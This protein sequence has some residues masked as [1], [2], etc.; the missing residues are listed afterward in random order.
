MILYKTIFLAVGLL[1]F[2][3][4]LFAQ[5]FALGVRDG[6]SISTISPRES[7]YPFEVPDFQPSSGLHAGIEGRLALGRRFAILS[8]L[9][10]DRKGYNMKVRFID[11][12]PSPGSL[13]ARTIFHCINLYVVGNYTIWKG[14]SVQAGLSRSRMVDVKREFRGQKYD[15]E[16]N[17]DIYNELDFNVLAGLEYQFKEPFFLAVRYNLGLAPVVDDEY[18]DQ[19]G[20][21][22]ERHWY[23]RSAQISVGYRYYFEK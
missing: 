1:L 7:S 3:D 2:T 22:Y 21:Q 23:N 18:T 11:S 10:Y 16:K 12:P 13:Y 17:Y 8:G 19:E 20:Q 5:R 9:E 6:Y 14:L 4:L 15:P